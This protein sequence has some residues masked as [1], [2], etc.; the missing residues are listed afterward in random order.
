M[1]PAGNGETAAG[2]VKWGIRNEVDLLFFPELFAFCWLR[3][4]TESYIAEGE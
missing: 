4:L 1:P 3:D 2:D